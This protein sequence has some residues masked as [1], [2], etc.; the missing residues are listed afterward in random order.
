MPVLYC[1]SMALALGCLL[2]VGCNSAP[3]LV[4]VDEPLRTDALAPLLPNPDVGGTA[5][6]RG[7]ARVLSGVKPQQLLHQPEHIS[8]VYSFGLDGHRID[9]QPDRD[10]KMTRGGIARTPSSRIPDFSD[11]RYS[12]AHPCSTALLS[13]ECAAAVRDCAFSSCNE[14]YHGRPAFWFSATEPRNPAVVIPYNIYIDYDAAVAGHIIHARPVRSSVRSVT[15]LGDSIGRGAHTV[16]YFV[17]DT[18]GQSWCALLGKALGPSVQV[19]NMSIAGATIDGFV[20]A[21]QSTTAQPP[22][23]VLI[24]A[25]GMNDHVAGSDGLPAFINQLDAIVQ[26]AQRRG[27]TVVLVGFFAQNPMWVM[28]KPS[29]TVQYNF[30]I[31]S[32]SIKRHIQFID[33]KSAFDRA[34]PQHE[35]YYHLTADFMHHPNIYGQRIYFSNILPVFLSHDRPASDFEDYVVGPW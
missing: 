21:Y 19:K 10:W 29:D 30:A 20:R 13:R 17:H 24:I 15:C 23:D 11:Y 12:A 9:Y 7:E 1:R 14:S 31:R 18:D 22:A 25:P 26:T 33:I 8:A 2:I 35:T 5:T 4:S 34:T 28:E 32:I 6:V 3:N 27:S 16:E